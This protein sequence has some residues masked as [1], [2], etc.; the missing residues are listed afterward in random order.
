[1]ADIQS[2]HVALGA[3]NQKQKEGFLLSALSQQP[4]ESLDAILQKLTLTEL[5]VNTKVRLVFNMELFPLAHSY[6]AGKDRQLQWVIPQVPD[7]LRPLVY[8][9]SRLIK[10]FQETLVCLQHGR[11]DFVKVFTL[12]NPENMLEMVNRFQ[13]EMDSYTS[14]LR[15][16]NGRFN[17]PGFQRRGRPQQPS[18]GER[19]GEVKEE[20]KDPTPAETPAETAT[21]AEAASAAPPVEPKEAEAKPKKASARAK[22]KAPEAEPPAETQLESDK[23]DSDGAAPTEQ[24]DESGSTGEPAAPDAAT[25]S[26]S[27]FGFDVLA[28]SGDGDRAAE[29]VDDG[30]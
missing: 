1:M 30:K 13:Q 8:A 28:L 23:P 22:N 25:P 12:L 2:I 15:E 5:P 20:I 6:R 3:L 29:S 24:Q 14:Q 19:A 11:G 27:A 21:A 26:M 16:A 17:R 4:P 10:E 7:H 9:T 18:T